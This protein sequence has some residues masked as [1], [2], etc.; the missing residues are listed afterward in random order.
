MWESLIIVSVIL[1]YFFTRNQKKGSEEEVEEETQFEEETEKEVKEE[2]Q[3]DEE[4]E[5]MVNRL[6]SQEVEEKEEKTNSLKDRLYRLNRKPPL[7]V[8]VVVTSLT[9]I[10]TYNIFKT[11]KG[12]KWYGILYYDINEQTEF[13][14]IYSPH[15]KDGRF[16]SENECMDYTGEVLDDMELGTVGDY[17]CVDEN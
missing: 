13:K 12:G 2:T 3:F 1:V 9:F 7:V 17:E 4:T 8:I 5:K 11:F 6:L 15:S 10:L 16:N 14:R